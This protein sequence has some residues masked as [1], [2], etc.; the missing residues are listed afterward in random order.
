MFLISLPKAPYVHYIYMDMVLANPKHEAA[1][2]IAMLAHV[3]HLL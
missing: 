3:P 1:T 2:H